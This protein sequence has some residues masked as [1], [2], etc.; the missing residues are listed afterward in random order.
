M[1]S[2]T[3]ILRSLPRL[4]VDDHLAEVGAAEGGG[5]VPPTLDTSDSTF[6]ILRSSFRDLLLILDHLVVR[7]ALGGLGDNDHLVG[8][9]VGDE[10]FGNDDEHPDCGG[11]H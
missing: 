2:F 7:S 8:V 3:S 1:I 4:E 5:G 10:A 9:L 6:G 11:Q